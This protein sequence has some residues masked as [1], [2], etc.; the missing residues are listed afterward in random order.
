MRCILIIFIK[1]LLNLIV[2]L[3]FDFVFY[4]L[5]IFNI[6]LKEN[7]FVFK[8]IYYYLFGYIWGITYVNFLLGKCLYNY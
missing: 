3:V 7:K 5:E 2:N 6:K 8:L 4:C 1:S